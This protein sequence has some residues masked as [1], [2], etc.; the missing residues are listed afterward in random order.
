MK[1]LRS[2]IR[3]SALVVIAVLLAGFSLVLYWGFA[4]L[5]H[6]YVD[7]RL[8]GAAQTLAR[9]I[10]ERPDLLRQPG[11]EIIGVD[12]EHES[13][14]KQHE[15][16]ETA[17]SIVVLTL[18][19][20]PVWKGS[21][22]MPRPPISPERLQE[23]R[24]GEPA[25]ETIATGD[26]APVRRVSVPIRFQ[27]EIRYVLQAETSLAFSQK[28]LRGLILLLVTVSTAFVA[29]AWIA[30]D[31]LA[32]KVLV[33]VKL[34]STTAEAITASALKAR[35]ILDSPYGEL[36]QL[37]DA[38]NAMLDR[39]QKVFEA[40]RRFVDHAAHE[41]QT[42]LTVLQGNLEV[43]LQKA[44]TA[45]DYRETLVGNL[46][47][48][49]RLVSLARSLLTLARF[50][51]DR[52]P[53]QLVPLALEPLL[54]E[55]VQDLAILAEEQQIRLSF[56]SDSAPP[57]MGDAE[58]LKQVVINLL[59]N[60]LRYTDPGGSVTVRLSVL[61]H[62]VVVTVE[63]TGH[64]IES[65]HLPYLF[66]RFYRADRARARDSGG[67]GLGLP[68]VKEIVEAHGGRVE[69]ASQPGKGTLFAVLLPAI[70]TEG[71]VSDR[72]RSAPDPR[73]TEI[74]RCRRDWNSPPE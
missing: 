51:G 56:H 28:A 53:V 40:Q 31:W 13:D 35:A 4:N 10:A 33:P 15:L 37:T 60:A 9:L 1:T 8:L 73:A 26:V 39:L 49:E 50:A 3:Y 25:F 52:P 48:V 45:E 68:I 43:A 65:E 23:V 57:I 41:M 20:R 64:G 6:Q 55:I 11:E 36:H 67:T 34:L 29:I 54:R 66:D 14:E 63:D 70:A 58:R 44:R 27:G 62:Q 5:L 47:Q 71:H 69:V 18:D 61:G 12:R 46:K 17:L 24:G 74:E 2:D 22:V 19:G 72:S 32:R 21:H 30:S 59:D 16:R 7:G 38:F 42:P